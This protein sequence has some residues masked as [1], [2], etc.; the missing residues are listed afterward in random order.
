[1]Q[2]SEKQNQIAEVISARVAK[3]IFLIGAIGTS[4]TYGAAV[5][6]LSVAW[7]YPDSLIPVG[8]KHLT[9]LKRGTYFSFR[10]AA[11]AMGLWPH[12]S[13][14][15]AE[16]IWTL[17]IPQD[18]GTVKHSY[19]M[20]LELDHT[21]DRQFSKVKSINATCALID[22]ADGVLHD[23]HIALFSRTGRRNRN[24]APRFILDTCNPNEAWVK[25]EVYDKWHTPKDHGELTP[26]MAVI[27]FVVKD[28]FLGEEYYE[29]FI[30][31]PNT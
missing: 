16:L 2:I 12:I 18:D 6:I 24:G 1:M 13:E 29:P 28:S 21:K 15:K 8:R 25:S 22:E 19:I 14:N 9:E 30:N 7:N 20:F 23:A 10:E 5:A 27:E 3:Q 4:K 11:E 17:T 26:D 31:M